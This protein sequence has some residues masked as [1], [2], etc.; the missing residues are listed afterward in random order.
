MLFIFEFSSPISKKP[1]KFKGMIGEGRT[2]R[3]GWLWFAVAIVTKHDYFSYHAYI[4][5]G[6]TRAY[7]ESP[8]I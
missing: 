8:L 4:E 1:F 2:Y 7:R 5:S 6:R 3:F